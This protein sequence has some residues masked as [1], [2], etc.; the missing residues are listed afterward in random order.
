MIVNEL[1]ERLKHF[2]F[3]YTILGLF[4]IL[5]IVFIL[6]SAADNYIK[7]P[8]EIAGNKKRPI[9]LKLSS[10][11]LILLNNRSNY[12]LWINISLIE[13]NKKKYRIKIRPLK[14]SIMD[15]QLNIDDTLFNLYK[16][17]KKRKPVYEFFKQA[18]T[19]QLE[20]SSPLEI[21][22]K[23][24]GVPIGTYLME[25][26]I[27]EQLRDEKNDYFIRLST[28]TH[29][30]RNV[31]FEIK[32]GNTKLVKRY[33][34][35][36]QLAAYFV[37]F[38]LFSYDEPLDLDQLVFHFDSRK[39]KF[40]PYL[41]MDTVIS[42]LEKRKQAF[43]K[44]QGKKKVFFEKITDESIQNLREKYR[45]QKYE[46]L[47]ALIVEAVKKETQTINENIK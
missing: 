5:T 6:F 17:D 22:L 4:S 9:E 38:S 36:N 26:N 2:R 29:F 47:I 27:Y 25:P 14:Q 45:Q 7:T 19:W 18:D 20:R 40:S 46:P 43:V 31:F 28:D 44:P 1:T 13:T 33:C 15:F 23:I 10:S 12:N 32:K 37:F 8:F 21:R 34:D 11:D 35:I 30:M 16:L 24:N 41:T 42:S 39:N 3:K